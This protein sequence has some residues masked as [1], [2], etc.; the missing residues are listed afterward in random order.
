MVCVSTKTRCVQLPLSPQSFASYDHQISGVQSVRSFP[1]DME[2]TTHVLAW[3]TDVY[4][5]LLRP[6]RGFDTLNEDFSF[7]LLIA[8]LLTLGGGVAAMQ[9]LLKEARLHH[10]WK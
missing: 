5:V 4:Y 6:A 7:V 1:T 9:H 10:K 3:G 2:S 8:A